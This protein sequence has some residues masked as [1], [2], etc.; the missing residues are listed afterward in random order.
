MLENVASDKLTALSARVDAAT[1][2]ATGY[3]VDPSW[4]GPPRES[5]RR[6]LSEERSFAQ[7]LAQPAY[8]QRLLHASPTSKDPVHE[9]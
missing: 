7:L 4:A 2:F 9:R 5:E 3:P 1:T 8:W 6:A